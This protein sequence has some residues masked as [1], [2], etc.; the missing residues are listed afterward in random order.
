[1]RE[2]GFQSVANLANL[3]DVTLLLKRQTWNTNRAI[4]V[5]SPEQAPADL[6]GCMRQL[7]KRIALKSGFFPFFW[8]VGIQV[9][10]IAPDISKR[11]INS[12]RHVAGVDNQWA[13]I[14]SLYLVDSVERTHREARTWGQVVTGKFQDAISSTLSRHFR[15]NTKIKGPNKTSPTKPPSSTIPKSPSSTSR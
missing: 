2:H 6:R 5:T 4:V 13:I 12:A 9:V 10:V 3:P 14:Q 1:M 11:D 8:G 15:P 7:R